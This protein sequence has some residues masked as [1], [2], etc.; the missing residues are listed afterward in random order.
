MAHTMRSSL[1]FLSLLFL[2]VLSA[3]P[4]SLGV[5]AQVNPEIDNLRAFAKLYGYVR[6]FHPSDEAAE[7]DWEAF[8]ALGATRVKGAATPQELKTVLERLFLPVAPTVRIYE[9]GEAPPGLPPQ[10]SPTDADALEIVA[11][12]HLGVGFGA[13]NSIYRSVRLNRETVL[14]GGAGNAVLTQCLDAQELAGR[15]VRLV[16]FGRA[17]E[18]AAKVQL[19]LRVDLEAGGMGFFDNMMDRP[20]VSGDWTDDPPIM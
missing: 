19:W 5:G 15:E 9:S 3:A 14:A 2:L 7:L 11:W 18:P 17:L 16:G 8:A 13:A 1:R 10:L 4:L 12:Q 6:Y 20:V